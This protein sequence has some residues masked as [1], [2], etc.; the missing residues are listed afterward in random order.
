MSSSRL[1]QIA[2][3][4]CEENLSKGVLR[5]CGDGNDPHHHG[6]VMRAFVFNGAGHMCGACGGC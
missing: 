6:G 1:N 2:L 4:E 5:N 3:T